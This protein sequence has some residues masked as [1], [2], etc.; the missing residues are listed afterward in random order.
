[1]AQSG[2]GIDGSNRST[3]GLDAAL[4]AVLAGLLASRTLVAWTPLVHFDIDPSAVSREAVIPF[5]GL[6][7]AGSLAIDAVTCGISAVLL[8]RCARFGPPWGAFT[9]ILAGLVAAIDVALVL[10]GD[11]ENLWR[12]SAWV[13][14]CLGAGSL[15]ACSGH[16]HA[17]R[18]QRIALTVLLSVGAVW[19]VRGA[20]QL[21]VEHPAMVSQFSRARQ[22]FLAAQGWTEGSVQAQTYER[23]LMQLEATG[24]FGLSNLMAGLVGAIG[25]A[26]SLV[27]VRARRLLKL[28]AASILAL[29]IAGCGAIELVNGSKGAIAAAGLGLA[30][31]WWA[32]GSWWRARVALLAA[33]VIPTAAVVMRGLLGDALDERSLLFRSQYWVGAWQIMQ[34][35]WPWGCGPDSFQAAYTLHRPGLAVEEVTSAHAAPVDW[36]ATLG[37]AGVAVTGAWAFLLMQCGA[38]NGAPPRDT[39]ADGV[40]LAAGIPEAWMVVLLGLSVAGIVAVIGDPA[41]RILPVVGLVLAAAFAW[42]L[43]GALITLDEGGFR[44]VG[45]GLGVVLASHAMIEMTLWQP[46]SASWVLGVIGVLAIHRAAVPGRRVGRGTV[47]VASCCMIGLGLAQWR[48]AWL[49]HRQERDVDAAV[50]TLV[51]NLFT[52]PARARAGEQLRLAFEDQALLRRHTLLLKSADQFLQAGLAERDP[53]RARVWFGEALES[54][55]GALDAFPLRSTLVMAAI[56]DAMAERGLTGWDQVVAVRRDVLRHDPRHTASLVRLAEA[57]AEAGDLDEAR[58]V[59]RRALDVDDSFR[60]DPLRQL[61]GAVRERCAALAAEPTPPADASPG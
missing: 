11:F 37:L 51:E 45:V 39:D 57:H 12:G 13:A 6:G 24:W 33:L 32:S 23:R 15:A 55:R 53:A 42:G 43:I 58:I 30:A 22:E 59:A 54:A 19:L 26:T 14:A 5:A 29:C 34:E 60:M 17:V 40:K 46:G 3:P 38:R 56:L 61:P 28:P 8:A 21:L 31:A 9:M 27:L 20:W 41:G 7:P 49:T 10:R 52:A 16:P 36:I 25:V 44:M 48:V 1:M 35:G 47:V 18:L 2:D 50:E 4:V